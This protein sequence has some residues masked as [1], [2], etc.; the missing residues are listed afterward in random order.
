MIEFL[1]GRMLLALR[2]LIASL[3]PRTPRRDQDLVNLR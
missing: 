3:L 1:P 2:D